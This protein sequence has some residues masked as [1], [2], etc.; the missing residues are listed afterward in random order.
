MVIFDQVFLNKYGLLGLLITTFIS[1]SIIPVPSEAVI[2]ASLVLFNPFYTFI[3]TLI[4]STL[5]SITNYHIGHKGIKRL[6]KK[7]SKIS[8]KAR[9]IFRKHETLSILL[10]SGFPLIGDPLIVLAG[11]LEMPFWKFFI[12]STINK[13]IYF[14]VLIIFGIGFESLIGI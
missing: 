11:S 2:L 3:F 8:Q 9:K 7:E 10:L 4:G 12:Y 6:L 1:Y 13:I 5:G 14:S